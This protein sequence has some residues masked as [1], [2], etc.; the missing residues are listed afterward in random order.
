MHRAPWTRSSSFGHGN[1]TWR[2]SRTRSL[3]GRYGCLARLYSMKP[4]ALPMRRLHDRLVDR[5]AGIL[6]LLDRG[7]HAPIVVGHHLHEL[8]L[9]ALPVC[10][11]PLRDR[12]L[13]V[14]HVALEQLFYEI[15]IL[16]LGE[17]LQFHHAEIAAALEIT[18]AIEHISNTARHTGREVAA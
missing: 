10:Q 18:L 6:R 15:H 7:K 8:R 4:V 5:H 16:G 2:Q 9:H 17:R 11:K 1:I 3:T 12:A 14:A 13:G